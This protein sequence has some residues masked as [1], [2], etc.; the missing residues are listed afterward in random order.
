M[1]HG[2]PYLESFFIA[3]NFERF[4]T[5][6]FNEPRAFWFYIPI[7]IGGMMPWAGYLVVLPARSLQAVV[8]RTRQIDEGEWRLLLWAFVPFLF[9]TIS[10]GKQPRY[11]LPLLP[12]LAI[13]LARSITT[14]IALV[15]VSS[16]LRIATWTTVVLYAVLAVLLVRARLLFITAYPALTWVG[17][18]AIGGATLVL[19]WAAA[20]ARWPRLP[21]ILT[22]CAVVLLLSIQ[23]GALAGRRPEPVEEMATLIR[24]HRRGNEPVGAYQVL[25]RNLPFYTRFKQVE[26]FD[27]SRALDFMKSGERVLLVIGMNDLTRLKTMSGIAMR[28]LGAGHYLDPANIRLRTLLS[29]MPAQDLDIVLLVTN[30]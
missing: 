28:P 25:V 2:A 13:L 3:D 21:M 7:L 20:T 17:V 12:P 4:A 10:I 11:I 23:F 6:R 9:Y 19:A 5:D 15:R 29:P 22:S 14:R 30:R 26:L 1:E 8:T 27:E 24:S 18:A 16:D